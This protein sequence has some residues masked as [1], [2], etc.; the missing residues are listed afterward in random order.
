M[1]DLGAEA[2]DVALGFDE[3]FRRFAP[4]VARVG[5]R[6]LGRTDDLQ[7]L[8]QDVFLA[9]H[10]GMWRLRDAGA[11]KGWLATVTVRIARRKLR[12]A[13]VR[14]F[15]GFGKTPETD[16]AIDPGASP[17]DRA[18]LSSIYRVLEGV[19]AEQRIAWALHRIEG[20]SLERVAEM[21]D[22]SLAT[23]KRRIAAAQGVLQTAVALG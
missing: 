20:E 16:Q 17:E 1:R 10:K 7:D 15:F 4:Y 22:C 5:T 18:L 8:V 23:V 6:I 2:T 11:T 12:A 9:A 3:A 13:K 21:T 19:P 14:A